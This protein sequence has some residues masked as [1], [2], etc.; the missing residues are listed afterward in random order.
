MGCSVVKYEIYT[1]NVA[2]YVENNYM[3]IHIY[4]YV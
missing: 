2:A 3:F 1:K 4:V